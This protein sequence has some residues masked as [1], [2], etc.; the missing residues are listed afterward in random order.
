MVAYLEARRH[1]GVE[2]RHLARHMLGL[3]HGEPA[4][5]RWRRLLSDSAAL[6]AND[7]GLLLR[8]RDE[9]EAA[10]MRVPLAEAA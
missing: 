5:R 8:A 2:V 7:P 9:V 3:Y 10:A 6:A 1:D 4:A